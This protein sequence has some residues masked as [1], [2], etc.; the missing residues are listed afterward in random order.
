MNDAA[1]RALRE[2]QPSPETVLANIYSTDVDPT[3][4]AFDTE[5]S[6]EASSGRETTMIDLIN[7]TLRDEMARDG[8]IV[9]FG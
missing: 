4:N 1:D 8:R 7:T 6:P 3:S 9:V 2:S 5:D